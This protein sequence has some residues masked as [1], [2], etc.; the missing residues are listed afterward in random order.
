MLCQIGRIKQ[1]FYQ[2]IDAFINEEYRPKGFNQQTCTVDYGVQKSVD[3]DVFFDI[4]YGG[5]ITEEEL[6]RSKDAFLRQV[7]IWVNTEENFL[8]FA[9]YQNFIYFIRGNLQ[10]EFIAPALVSQNSMGSSIRNVELPS[11]KK[12]YSQALQTEISASQRALSLALDYADEERYAATL[13]DGICEMG[14]SYYSLK[15]SMVFMR[16]YL[17]ILFSYTAYQSVEES[18]NCAIQ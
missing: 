1:K 4:L 9:Q 12:R 11:L 10:K 15:E 7:D 5:N 18:D 2:D 17:T 3:M 8:D 13:I 6:I 16:A 14:K